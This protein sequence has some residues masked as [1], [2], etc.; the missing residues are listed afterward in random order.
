VLFIGV[1]LL[2]AAFWLPVARR[3]IGELGLRPPRLRALDALG[4]RLRNFRLGRN[5]GAKPELPRRTG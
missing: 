1:Q 2:G 4:Q 5:H 3:M